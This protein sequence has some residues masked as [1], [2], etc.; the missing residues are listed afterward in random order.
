[1]RDYDGS[2]SRRAC[3][4][5]LGRQGNPFG[6]PRTEV[7]GSLDRLRSLPHS[8]AMT[9]TSVR[10]C[11]AP[12]HSHAPEPRPSPR[13][14]AVG[15]RDWPVDEQNCGLVIEFGCLAPGRCHRAGIAEPS[16][17]GGRVGLGRRQP[18]QWRVDHGQP[19][20]GRS[21]AQSDLDSSCFSRTVRV[22]VTVERG[23]LDQIDEAATARGLT[24]SAFLAQAA[25]E[26]IAG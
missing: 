5:V 12:A 9:D 7:R 22:N 1:M 17:G 18:A 16:C 3:G 11:F 14:A 10:G 2:I 4:S 25:R 24:R 13:S 6:V 26:K 23:L 20:A 21:T 8:A 19:F 15:L